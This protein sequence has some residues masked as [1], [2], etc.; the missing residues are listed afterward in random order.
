[1]GLKVKSLKLKIREVTE[2]L[3]ELTCPVSFDATFK[4]VEPWTQK[5]LY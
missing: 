4:H 3:P 5:P 2:D 1:M